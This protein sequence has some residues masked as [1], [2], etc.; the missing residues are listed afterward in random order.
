LE[1]RVCKQGLKRSAAKKIPLFVL[2]PASPKIN[3]KVERLNQTWKDEFY[4]MNYNDLSV[5][6]LE[7]NKQIDVWQK[8]YNEIRLHRAL[9][10]K[11]NNLFTPLEFLKQPHMS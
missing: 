9:K 6:L 2:P 11:N 10:D 1:T 7:L 8:Y 5:N 3:D 4:L